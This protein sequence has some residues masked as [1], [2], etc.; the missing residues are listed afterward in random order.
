M[1]ESGQRSSRPKNKSYTRIN[2]AS[3]D[4]NL[5]SMVRDNGTLLH[6]LQKE[7]TELRKKL[8]DLNLKLNLM[9]EKANQKIPKK[10]SPQITTVDTLEVVKKNLNYY[11]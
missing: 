6:K 11:E 10:P 8:K 1:I 7:N 4:E 3:A 9:I 2:P 5:Y